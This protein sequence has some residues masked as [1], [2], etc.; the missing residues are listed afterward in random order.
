M[1]AKKKE[2]VGEYALGGGSGGRRGPVPVS[3]HD[4]P[5]GGPGKVTPYGVYD[6]GANSGFVK[7][8]IDHDTAPFAVESLRSWWRAGAAGTPARAVAGH[9]GCRRL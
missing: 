2:Q 8:G 7:V 4:F 3:G 6:I 5:E 1:D 9:R